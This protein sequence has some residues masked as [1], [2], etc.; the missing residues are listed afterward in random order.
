MDFEQR[1]SDATRAGGG[2]AV[3]GSAA[4]SEPAVASGASGASV[5]EV[6]G[7]G[8]NA[9][10]CANTQIRRARQAR[11][12]RLARVALFAA[13][14]LVLSYIETM[15]PLPV[16][17]P[18]VKLGLANIAVVVALFALDIRT[19]G[20]VAV[21]KILASGFLFG[22]P[23]MLAYSAGGTALAFAG[24]V[25]LY[26]VPGISV[27]VV[28]LAS[29][30]LHNVGQILVACA[31]LGSTAALW[32]LPPLAVAACVTG[33]LTGM[34]AAGVL[35]GFRA[36]ESNQA[37]R[38]L[39]DTSCLCLWPGEHL[40][41]V[42]GNGSG[43]TS[44][45]LQL[46]GL[47]HVDAAEGA[48]ESAASCV[49]V[50][51]NGVD[52]HEKLAA[53][54]AGVHDAGHEDVQCRQA[55]SGVGVAFQDPDDQI[56]A[57]QVRDDVAFGPENRGMP[58]EA[59]VGVVEQALARAGASDLL[60]RETSSLSGGQKQRV[61]VAGLLALAPG[62]VVFDEASAMLDPQARRAFGETVR[63]LCSE[64]VS[65]ITITQI[66][67]EAFQADRIA[68]FN[69][70][71]IVALCTPEELLQRADVLEQCGLELPH[72]AAL[73]RDFQREGMDVP[74]TND[75]VILE[76]ALWRLC[77]QA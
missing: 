30:V 26:R 19:A 14:A 15:I 10:C 75:P 31:M 67:D 39:V 46:A 49:D 6:A 28:S 17:L 72:T 24:M 37:Q 76:E 58:R 68:V 22:S 27:A 53:D 51:C 20:A 66:M 48:S 59:M 8:E 63:Q 71:A 73:A 3:C 23:M 12:Q 41:F 9:A 36:D 34:V 18:G 2:D 56:V 38:P 55:A 61:A 13:V 7:T 62:V 74:L 50:A 5:R 60:H 57:L 70:G 45:A 77:A 42:G 54:S 4:V 21:V 52:G 33:G 32:S 29:A 69:K 64:G 16:A 1:N 35:G 43:K 65:V 47:V 25:A 40:A 44:C 11:I